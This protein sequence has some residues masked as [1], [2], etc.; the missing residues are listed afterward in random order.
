VP[1]SYKCGGRHQLARN[2]P[3]SLPLSAAS[4]ARASRQIFFDYTPL[5][6]EIFKRY[7]HESGECFFL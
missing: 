3:S 1:P 2:I 4:V 6:R 5:T 7:A